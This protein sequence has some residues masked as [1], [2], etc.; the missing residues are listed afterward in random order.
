M[1]ISFNG[2]ELADLSDSLAM[3]VRLSGR[4]VFDTANVLQ[5][6]YKK[7]Y[8]RNKESI[9]LEFSARREFATLQEAQN[10][11]AKQFTGLSKAG[12][13][14]IICGIPG[15]NQTVLIDNAVL[16][17]T[18]VGVFNGVEVIHRYTIVGAIATAVSFPSSP[19]YILTEDGDKILTE[20]GDKIVLEQ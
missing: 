10:Y 15:D 19:S 18:P 14:E 12:Q 5:S 13:C 7:F 9:T 2:I 20:T 8:Y 4:T 1:R 11:L 6:T 17:A 16:T 3:D